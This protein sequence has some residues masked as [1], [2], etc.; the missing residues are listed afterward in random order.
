MGL[1]Y[2]YTLQK[3]MVHTRQSHF[4]DFEISTFL[5]KNE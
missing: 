2:V 3:W 1:Y 4:Q 5:T